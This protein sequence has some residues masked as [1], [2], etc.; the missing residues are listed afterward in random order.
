MTV[1]RTKLWTSLTAEQRHPGPWLAV[2]EREE[3][4]WV[5]RVSTVMGIR[6]MRIHSNWAARTLLV[7]LSFYNWISLYL[8]PLHWFLSVLS[9][10]CLMMF[11]NVLQNSGKVDMYCIYIIQLYIIYSVITASVL[12]RSSQFLP[13]VIVNN[14]MWQLNLFHARYRVFVGVLLIRVWYALLPCQD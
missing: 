2:V 13:G 12:V 4:S 7:Y 6:Q 11:E 14:F 9:R 5:M 8:Q 3:G 10:Q 1:S